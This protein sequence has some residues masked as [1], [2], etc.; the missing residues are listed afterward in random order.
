MFYVS[1]NSVNA[2]VFQV[3]ITNEEFGTYGIYPT[4]RVQETNTINSRLKTGKPAIWDLVI[5]NE[6]QPLATEMVRRFKDGVKTTVVI[7]AAYKSVYKKPWLDGGDHVRGE[8]HLKETKN[9]EDTLSVLIFHRENICKERRY[10]ILEA[11]KDSELW[12]GFQDDELG[13]SWFCYSSSGGR[14]RRKE[15]Q[16]ALHIIKKLT[17]GGEGD[18]DNGEEEECEDEFDSTVRS[19][20]NSTFNSAF[21]TES[22]NDTK[23]Q[24]VGDES[25]YNFTGLLNEL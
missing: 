20:P 15:N 23:E 2:F 7:W 22:F 25:Q 5:F 12:N 11:N 3:D 13:C 14:G 17:S 9:K 10:R 21:T 18:V 1:V 4:L 6:C 16:L 19:F 8:I 24:H